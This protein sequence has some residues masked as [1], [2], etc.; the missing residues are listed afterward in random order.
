MLLND[1]NCLPGKHSP[2]PTF[3]QS[4]NDLW[5]TLKPCFVLGQEAAPR[6]SVSI[7]NPTPA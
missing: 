4:A 7:Q 6:T 2:L 5:R 1:V 3:T